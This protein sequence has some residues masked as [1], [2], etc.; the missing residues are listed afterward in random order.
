VAK[1]WEVPGLAGDARFREAAGRVI[2]T[3]WRE[4]MSYRDGTL[5]GEDIEELHSMR[6]SSRRLRAAMDAFEGAFPRRTFTPL[7]RQVKEITDV[8]GNAR[9]LD[10]AIEG[11]SRLVPEIPADERPGIEGLVARYREDRAAESPRIEALFARLDD[12]RFEDQLA[13]YMAKHTG[14]RLQRLNPKPPED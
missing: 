12:E 6:V 8:L 13:R 14:I 10:V 11:L 5:L 3:R 4:M 1:A 9:D 7:L 2:L